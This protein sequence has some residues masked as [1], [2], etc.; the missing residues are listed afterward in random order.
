MARIIDD[1]K[2]AS[3]K[4]TLVD[5]I[6][7]D[8]SSNASIAKMAQ[9]AQVSSGY[10][11]RHYDSKESLLKD[12]YVEKFAHINQILLDEIQQ[13]ENLQDVI[14]GFYTQ[15]V[16][17]ARSNENEILFLLKMMTDYSMKISDQMRMDLG[18]TVAIFRNKFQKEINV[19]INAEQ[20]FIQMLGTILLFINMRKRGVFRQT[21]IDNYDINAMSEITLKALK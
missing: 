19:S 15:I 8:G 2:L 14:T 9:K 13:N 3:V 12:L 17:I 16:K 11:Y 6:V 1:S 20:I 4:K 10:L 18:K 7:L 21:D 5:I